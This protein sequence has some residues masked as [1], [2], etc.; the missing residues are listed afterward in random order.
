MTIELIQNGRMPT[1]SDGRTLCQ[2]ICSSTQTTGRTWHDGQPRELKDTQ[3]SLNNSQH[4]Q[5]LHMSHV[6]L[7][8]KRTAS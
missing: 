1:R 3:R 5:D 7:Y 6:E 2:A 4:Y 8:M